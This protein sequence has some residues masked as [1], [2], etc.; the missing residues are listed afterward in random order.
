MSGYWYG[1]Q[2]RIENGSRLGDLDRLFESIIAFHLDDGDSLGRS[3]LV[4]FRFL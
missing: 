3:L 1:V 2:L 4:A